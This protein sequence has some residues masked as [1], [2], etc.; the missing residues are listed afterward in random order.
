MTNKIMS[1]GEQ[2]KKEI[3]KFQ[4]DGESNFNLS[5]RKKGGRSKQYFV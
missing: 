2:Q 3:E 4:F 5:K 1:S